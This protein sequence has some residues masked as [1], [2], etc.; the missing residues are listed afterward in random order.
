[1]TIEDTLYSIERYCEKRF[2]DVTERPFHPVTSVVYGTVGV[3]SAIF[4]RILGVITQYHFNRSYLSHETDAQQGQRVPKK[5]MTFNVCMMPGILATMFGSM[6]P[7]SQRIEGLSQ[8]ILDQG[9]DIVCLQEMT[10]DPA[11]QL[12]EKLKGTYRYFYYRIGPNP[13]GMENA[14]FWAS[15]Y[16]LVKDPVYIPFNVPNMQKGFRRGFFVAELQDRYVIMTHLDPHSGKGDVR[17]AEIQ[18]II[19][20][21]NANLTTK[22]VILIGDLNIEREDTR[23]LELLQNNFSNFDR[24]AVEKGSESTCLDNIP[25]VVRAPNTPS[26][27]TYI[28]HI[29]L[30]DQKIS[31]VVVRALNRKDIQASLSDHDAVVLTLS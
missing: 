13:L 26:K 1:M 4:S 12:I 10:F 18:A 25:S 21:K 29:L 23:A 6:T 3:I 31:Q 9:A 16:P 7:A 11:T 14:L 28:D 8:F 30:S 19:D 2:W 17:A 5:F 24:D 15:K 20:Y 27:Y 22:P